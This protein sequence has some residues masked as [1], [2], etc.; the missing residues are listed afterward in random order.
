MKFGGTSVNDAKPSAGRGHRGRQLK[1]DPNVVVVTSAM[2]G[3][4]DC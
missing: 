1:C 2:R 3:V 4:T